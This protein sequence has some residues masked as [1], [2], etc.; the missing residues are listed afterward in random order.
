MISGYIRAGRPTES[1]LMFAK[2]QAF[3]VEPNAFTLSAAI[4]ACSN[5]NDVKLG[6]CFHG[7][8]LLRGFD[9][10]HVIASALVDM[11]GK[12]SALEDA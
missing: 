10:N 9:L 7:M 11:Y 3:G 1:L 5:L 12:N 8:V 4:K 6:S 2:M